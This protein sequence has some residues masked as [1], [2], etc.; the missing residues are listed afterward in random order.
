MASLRLAL[1]SSVAD[2]IRVGFGSVFFS[3][4]FFLSTDSGSFVSGTEGSFAF[5]SLTISESSSFSMASRSVGERFEVSNPSISYNY[6][7]V[8]TNLNINNREDCSTFW[9]STASR[10]SSINFSTSAMFI[11]L[12]SCTRTSDP[13]LRPLTNSCSTTAN[14]IVDVCSE[15]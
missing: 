11:S 1:R 9:Y 8:S 2:F 4:S 13:V 14:S 10:V 6:F 12:L 7:A 3:C 15:A 5:I